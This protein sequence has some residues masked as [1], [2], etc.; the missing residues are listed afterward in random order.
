MAVDDLLEV[1]REILIK[2]GRRG[3]LSGKAKRF[4]KHPD[5]RFGGMNDGDGLHVVFDD[6]FRTRADTRQQ[7]REVTRRFRV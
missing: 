6:D 3:V 1:M 5:A 7:R 4:R 2:S